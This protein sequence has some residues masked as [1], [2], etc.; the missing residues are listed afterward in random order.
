MSD[1]VTDYCMKT[2]YFGETIN[3]FGARITWKKTC[4]QNGQFSTLIG[5]FG[6]SEQRESSLRRLFHAHTDT[7]STTLILHNTFGVWTNLHGCHWHARLAKLDFW[8]ANF[9]ST[10]QGQIHSRLKLDHDLIC[11]IYVIS[12]VISKHWHKVSERSDVT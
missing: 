10:I 4:G 2:N 1:I 7:K 5:P 12:M 11:N 8:E 9:A 6:G 3:I